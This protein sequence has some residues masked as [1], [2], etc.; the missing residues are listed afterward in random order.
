M[1]SAR[2]QRRVHCFAGSRQRHG[3]R[4]RQ[5]SCPLEMSETQVHSWSVEVNMRNVLAISATVVVFLF[6]SFPAQAQHAGFITGLAPMSNPVMPMLNPVS[7]F[8][9]A[10]LGVH[11]PNQVQIFI[12]TPT[13]FF[14]HTQTRL[15]APVHRQLH[16]LGISHLHVIPHT[17]SNVIVPGVAATQG[18]IFI[19]PDH[20]VRTGGFFRGRHKGF[21]R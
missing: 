11:F 1:Y 16:A 8:S 13:Q 6:I 15:F 17:F 9:Q 5:L 20:R 3:S 4:V 2:N 12:G 18:P 7:P 14:G 19:T 10:P 21:R